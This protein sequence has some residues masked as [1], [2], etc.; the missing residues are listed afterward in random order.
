MKN[1]NEFNNDLY[2]LQC[3]K[4]GLTNNR[5]LEEA[6]A[7]VFF[8]RAIQVEQG[9]YLLSSFTLE[10]FKNLHEHLFQDIYPFAGQF[11]NVQLVKGNTRFCQH[12]FIET[13]AQVLFDELQNEE[14]WKSL[15][16]ASER[17]AYFKT[18]LNM[19]HP[20]REGNGRTIRIF[21]QKYALMKN[22]KWDITL[23]D[24]DLYLEA[25]IHSKTN[26][27]LLKELFLSTI[28]FN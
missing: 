28:E 20:F 7:F 23:I 9:S 13:N 6:E 25:M 3:N 19:L 21:I 17:L 16:E 8:I 15:D 5:D 11:R 1:Y 14:D 12:Q 22:I 24:R 18:E 2:L 26:P 27:Q 4:L 10:D